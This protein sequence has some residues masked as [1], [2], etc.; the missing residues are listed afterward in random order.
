M[1]RFA[2]VAVAAA[3]AA[4]VSFSGFA[5]AAGAAPA[6]DC[7]SLHVSATPKVNAQNAPFETIKNSVTSCSNS[8]ETVTLTQHLVGPFART[9][10]A[11]RTWT[12]ALAPGQTVVKVQHIPYSCCG[13]YTVT[14]RAVSGS[15][16]VLARASTGFTFA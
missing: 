2:A 14:D 5:G 12:I 11:I 15:G 3:A 9:T 13:S 16:H 6:A 1:S 4:V 8:A 7:V 10:A